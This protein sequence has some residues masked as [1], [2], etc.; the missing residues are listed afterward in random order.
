MSKS[1]GNYLTLEQVLNRYPHPDY[2]KLFFLKTH[3]RSPIDY[4]PERM[5]EARK[6]WQEFSRFFQHASQRE[7]HAVTGGLASAEAALA[8]QQFEAAMDDDLN[9]PQGL[10]AFFDLVNAG[11][12]ML[13]SS[14]S[15]V[16][17]AARGILDLLTRWGAILGLFRQGMT[18]EP[19][20][21]QQR[22][23]QLVEQRDAARKAK[24]FKRADE[25]RARLQQ[26]GY[27]LADT[28]GGTLWR[29]A[30]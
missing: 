3:Y 1:L 16:L 27:L 10:A 17:F 19:P 7:V 15:K 23:Q 5:E 8:Q 28:A 2:L 20:A 29:R 12:R 13:E 25:I 30:E 21:Q 14:D 24:D 9:T 11:H 26:E 4:S 6:N 22:V 18:E